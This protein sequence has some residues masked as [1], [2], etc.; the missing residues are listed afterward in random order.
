M[1]DWQR[2]ACLRAEI[3][4]D[5]FAEVVALFLEEVDEALDRLNGATT[6]AASEAALHFLKGSALN[7]GFV[8][9]AAICHAG[10]REAAAGKAVDA[11][12]ISARYRASRQEFLG[13]HPPGRKPSG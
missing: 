11:R 2:V 13:K 12:A 3:G 9:F 7:I 6:P 8:D 1:I 4:E 10:E 5:D